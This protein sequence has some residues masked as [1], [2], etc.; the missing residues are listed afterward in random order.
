MVTRLA[1]VEEDVPG[2]R[3]GEREHALRTHG[4][5]VG[6]PHV[7]CRR[8]VEPACQ[9]NALSKRAEIFI[10][11]THA[12]LEAT[13]R[14]AAVAGH[15]VSVVAL[16]A[17][18]RI[19]D[20]VAAGLVALAVGGA[21]VA[22]PTVSVVAE[23]VGIERAIAAALV[24]LAVGRA[25][26]SVRGVAVV[27]DLACVGIERAVAAGLVAATIRRASVAAGHV[28]VIA[29]L[30]GIQHSIPA[31]RHA[32]DQTK[33]DVHR[34]PRAG[35][36]LLDHQEVLAGRQRLDGAHPRRGAAR[37]PAVDERVGAR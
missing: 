30:A 18:R 28:A 5:A 12:H 8:D 16:F 26:I 29:H 4:G 32:R 17:D 6:V 19:D 11:Q 37:I 9:W 31:S 25:A 34:S 33:G 15:E 35:H 10:H 20:G 2:T 1:H 13:T 36:V 7:A 24:A 27:A 23:L 3:Q 21:P 22:A 14:I